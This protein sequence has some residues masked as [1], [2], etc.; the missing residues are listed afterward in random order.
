MF[1]NKTIFLDVTI[2]E[3]GTTSDLVG[4]LRPI[5]GHR[6]AAAAPPKL[7]GHIIN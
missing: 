6:K 2:M 5:V 3:A 4:A 7:K 1:R